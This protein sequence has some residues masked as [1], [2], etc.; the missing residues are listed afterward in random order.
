MNENGDDGRCVW[1]RNKATAMMRAR[2]LLLSDGKN[3][4]NSFCRR[5]RRCRRRYCRHWTCNISDFRN[6]NVRRC[7]RHFQTNT[8]NSKLFGCHRMATSSL[9]FSLKM[10]WASFFYRLQ[11]SGFFLLSFRLSSVTVKKLK[12]AY[13]F[14]CVSAS[15]FQHFFF[16]RSHCSLLGFRKWFDLFF[17]IFICE[18]TRFFFFPFCHGI[19][20]RHKYIS[21]KNKLFQRKI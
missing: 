5:R 20:T 16:S 15:F 10:K 4:Y 1:M 13:R 6:V 18:Q 7:R 11:C 14:S 17:I 2:S 21:I 19:S 3:I 9:F 8:F 12:C